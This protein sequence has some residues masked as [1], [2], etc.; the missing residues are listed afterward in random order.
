MGPEV[1]R[2]TGVVTKKRE[3]TRT[4][5]LPMTILA[6][7]LSGIVGF[8]IGRTVPTILIIWRGG[9]Q[10]EA[11]MKSTT[12][13]ATT[14][15]SASVRPETPRQLD[16]EKLEKYELLVHPALF[17]HDI[18][19]DDDEEEDDDDDP[20][21]IRVAI[22]TDE[23]EPV[24]EILK[25]AYVSHVHVIGTKL[26]PQQHPNDPVCLKPEED[27]PYWTSHPQIHD[28]RVQFQEVTITTKDPES[29]SDLF[30][31]SNHTTT[32]FDVILVDG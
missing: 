21:T 23:I 10:T 19:V 16:T 17:I 18:V 2:R 13:T 4:I 6:L 31:P 1:R 3:S 11:S 8:S 27:R 25:H 32:P 24:L 12:T 7:F 30:M 29:C 26:N 14:T 9:F 22:W 20:Q 15:R 5:S 28:S